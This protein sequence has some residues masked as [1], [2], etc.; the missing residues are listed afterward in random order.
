MDSVI[1]RVGGKVLLTVYFRLSAMLFA[2][3]RDRNDSQSVLDRFDWFWSNA[4]AGPELFRR[5]FPV[6]LTDNG[7]E[8]SNP[9]AIESVGGVR[10]TSVFF[11]DACA[12]W[13]KGGIER[14][15]ELLR[16]ILPKGTSFDTLTQDDI[17]LILSH[18]NSYSRPS[19]SD[20]SPYELFAFSY[21]TELL[22]N[23]GIRRIA[24]NDIVLKPSLLAR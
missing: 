12:S 9:S 20:K 8:F 16:A 3:L 22:D 24:P 4:G 19:R 1:G 15:H 10:R 2:F 7:S 17:N 11:C 5:I 6:I 18:V 23:L 14:D 13:Q 21:G